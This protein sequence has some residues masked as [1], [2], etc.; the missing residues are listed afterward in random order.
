MKKLLIV[1]LFLIAPSSYALEITDVTCDDS[2]IEFSYKGNDGI[3]QIYLKVNTSVEK[4]EFKRIKV[5][6]N[7]IINKITFHPNIGIPVNIVIESKYDIYYEKS[8]L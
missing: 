2:G 7:N 4:L 6:N 3:K 8:C 1:L 5:K